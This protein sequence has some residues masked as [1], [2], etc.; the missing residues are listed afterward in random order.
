[1]VGDLPKC[2]LIYSPPAPIPLYGP[3]SVFQKQSTQESADWYYSINGTEGYGPVTL[4]TIE[5]M[6]QSGQLSGESYVCLPLLIVVQ[7]SSTIKETYTLC[8]KKTGN[9]E[10]GSAVEEPV[11]Q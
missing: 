7:S 8:R 10:R 3:P 6:L 4:T 5:Q 11:T 9:D 1:M 2:T